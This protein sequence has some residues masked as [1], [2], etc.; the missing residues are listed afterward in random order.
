MIK[1]IGIGFLVISLTPI[2][3]LTNSR[4]GDS[5]DGAGASVYFY[6][7][8]QNLFFNNYAFDNGGIRYGDRTFPLFKRMVGIENVP[9]NFW[10][11]RVKYPNLKINDEFFIN[12]VG[13]FVLDF[14]PIIASIIFLIVF[15]SIGKLVE[16]KGSNILFHQLIL[17]HFTLTLCVQGGIKLYPFSDV[18]G[19][20]QLIFYVLMYFLFLMDYRLR[21]IKKIKKTSDDSILV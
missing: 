6:V 20:L 8:Q 3:L 2:V 5:L 16:V 10:E 11:R 1:I 4:F 21:Q 14:G 19:N 15:F 9:N 17:I 12:F 7:G 18:G 13:D